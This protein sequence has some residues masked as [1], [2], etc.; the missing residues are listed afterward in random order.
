MKKRIITKIDRKEANRLQKLQSLREKFYLFSTTC[1]RIVTKER[2]QIPFDWNKAQKY[3]HKRL[4]EQRRQTGGVVRA[5]IL[6]GR[7]QGI[8]TYVAARFYHRASLFKFVTVYILSH[9]QS[10]ADTLFSIVDRYHKLN[11][12]RPHVGKDNQ[13]EMEFDRL[14]SS[15]AVA[16]AG[17]GEGGRSKTATLFHGSEVAFWRN[18][19]AHFS[20][21]VQTVPYADGTEIILESTANGPMGKFYDLWQEAE[22]GRGDYIAIFVPWFWQD[23][24][25]RPI[26]EGFELQDDG[27][28]DNISE[29][30]Y[31]DTFKPDG[32]TMEHM[33]WRRA[34]VSEMGRD[35][36][37]Q[38]YPAT[39]QMAFVSTNK[40]NYIPSLPVLKARK[41]TIEGSGPL[42]L[43]IDPSGEGGDRFAITGRRGR[44]VEFVKWRDHLNHLEAY[45][46]V[47][48]IYKE[49][50]PAKMFI[51][52]G[53]IGAAVITLLRQ[54]GDIPN[55]VVVS[56]NFGSPS[57]FK[58]MFKNSG[59]NQADMPPGPVNR[60]AEMYQ[61]MKE[62]FE[63]EEGVSIP[64]LDVLQ[65]D[66]T[67]TRIKPTLTNDLQLESKHDMRKRGIRSPDLA[68]S[69]GLTFASL[70][71]IESYV[72]KGQRVNPLEPEAV[73]RA[74]NDGNYV[75]GS[76][77]GWM[78]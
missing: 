57:Q 27:D 40:Q 54:D 15:Y 48:S 49:Y 18:A 39:A 73:N 51:D 72:E 71:R 53:N 16:T 2:Q 50:L 32:L 68:D 74:M 59:R 20:A 3:V 19:D 26:P 13:S 14:G 23:E 56:V 46:W 30:E 45:Q 21:S 70:S 34:K 66:L 55:S 17:E 29:E 28:E 35:K 44:E 63:L 58:M 4:E 36:F 5:L 8:S 25:R 12:F 31:Y 43:G 33:V 78:A 9:M 65:G 77:H 41:R 64:D 7:Q 37:N 11:E 75:G 6:K 38:E 22:A 61:R 62:W 47:K 52:A 42:I 76:A 10:S 67:A 69:L 24:Y 60:R 1:L